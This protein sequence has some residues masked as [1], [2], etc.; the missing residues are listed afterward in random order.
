MR[1]ATCLSAA[2][3]LALAASMASADI[4]TASITTQATGTIG[5]QAFRNRFVTITE[6][7]STEDLLTCEGCFPGNY[8][9]DSLDGAIT[10]TV[11]VFGIGTFSG[12]ANYAFSATGAEFS[13]ADVEGHFGFGGSTG[14]SDYF[15]SSGPT[16]GPPT[17]TFGLGPSCDN[18]Y[19]EFDCPVHLSSS[20][21]DVVLT[22]VGGYTISTITV[23]P[24]VINVT[25]EPSTLVLLGT[26]LLSAGGVLRR[27]FERRNA[28]ANRG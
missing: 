17:D 5:S 25:P 1:F 16:L 11:R 28:S 8:F 27:R 14:S 13:L 26:G 24:S 9:L 3:L 12:N 20:G 19:P 4:I 23:R 2:A 21:G 18:F 15:H 22:G 10:T 6:R 7:F